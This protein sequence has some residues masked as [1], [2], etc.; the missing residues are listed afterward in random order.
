MQTFLTKVIGGRNASLKREKK[1]EPNR[2]V[3]KTAYVYAGRVKF[4]VT[5]YT[6]EY[7]TRSCT[8]CIHLVIEGHHSFSVQT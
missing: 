2:M 1:K 4:N 7:Q 6:Y 8:L 5:M 3:N